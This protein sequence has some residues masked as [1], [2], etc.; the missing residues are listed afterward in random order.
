MTIRIRKLALLAGL[1]V[2]VALSSGTARA[3]EIDSVVTH[4]KANHT[5][6]IGYRDTS[7]PLSYL[8]KDNKPTGYAV[9]FCQRIAEAMKR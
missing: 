9:E 5:F 1:A 6:T 3:Q 8:D 2:S 7:V 4:L